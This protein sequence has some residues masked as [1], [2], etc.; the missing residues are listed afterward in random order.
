MHAQPTQA[1]AGRAL[2]LPTQQAVSLGVRYD[3]RNEWSCERRSFERVHTS[4]PSPLSCSRWAIKSPHTYGPHDDVAVLKE[5]TEAATQDRGRQAGRQAPARAQRQAGR[6]AGRRAR[7]PAPSGSRS[8]PFSSAAA[9]LPSV[10]RT[11]PT[12]Q[13][14]G[15]PFTTRARSAGGDA[16]VC[17]LQCVLVCAGRCHI[18]AA[19]TSTRRAR[20]PR[21]PPCSVRPCA[22]LPATASLLRV[23]IHS[24]RRGCARFRTARPRPV[25]LELHLSGASDGVP[26][27][28]PLARSL[29]PSFP[30]VSPSVVTW[31]DACWRSMIPR[32][33]I[34]SLKKSRVTP[35]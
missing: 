21:R 23:Q 2:C 14:S 18:A 22:S 17:A 15:T 31:C 34:L 6:Q 25:Q 1:H 19:A 12:A 7:A 5:A 8:S 4:H 28:L 33:L 11:A 20:G 13:P 3:C 10:P 16:R 9:A 26:L 24:A 29:A 32:V 30:V 27:S 35:P